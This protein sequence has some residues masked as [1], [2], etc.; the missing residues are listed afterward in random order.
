MADEQQILLEQ[1]NEVKTNKVQVKD[2]SDRLVQIEQELSELVLERK[3]KKDQIKNLTF[4]K[5]KLKK[6]LKIQNEI[7]KKRRK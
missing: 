6:L 4:E 5:E 1:A 3:T 7:D 2:T